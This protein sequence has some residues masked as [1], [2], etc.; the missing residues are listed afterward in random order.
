MTRNC[1]NCNCTI[2]Y[3]LRRTCLSAE[4]KGSV[5]RSCRN[6][7]REYPTGEEHHYWGKDRSLEDRRKISIGKGGNGE[8][9]KFN[10]GKLSRWSKQVIKRDVCCQKCESTKDLHA[11]HIFQKALFPDLAYDLANGLTLC[12]GCH[13]ELHSLIGK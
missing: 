12:S 13:Y 9:H 8:L 7:Q 5:C 1:P 3:Q 10:R 6:K 2:T 4:R 11:H